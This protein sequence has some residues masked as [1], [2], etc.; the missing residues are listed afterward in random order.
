MPHLA[1]DEGGFGPRLRQAGRAGARQVGDGEE[2]VRREH[3]R[4]AA[5]GRGRIGPEQPNVAAEDRVKGAEV[6]RALHV[7]DE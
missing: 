5:K 2:S 6:G 1:L 7:A 4:E 3:A